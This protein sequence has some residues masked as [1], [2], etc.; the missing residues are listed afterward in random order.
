MYSFTIISSMEGRWEKAV[1][2]CHKAQL[3]SLVTLTD[4]CGFRGERCGIL[5]SADGPLLGE[6][7][8]EVSAM[9][10]SRRC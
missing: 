4:D 2:L 8:L 3:Q 5:E 9:K 10:D 6:T 7:M 1:L